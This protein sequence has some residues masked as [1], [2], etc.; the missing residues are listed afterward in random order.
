MDLMV[1]K[2]QKGDKFIGY[3]DKITNDK[4][5]LFL[6]AYELNAELCI[7]NKFYKIR[8]IGFDLVQKWYKKDSINEKLIGVEKLMTVLVKNVNYIKSK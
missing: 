5:S 7:N 4:K 1:K 6:L 2:F 8:R 3:E